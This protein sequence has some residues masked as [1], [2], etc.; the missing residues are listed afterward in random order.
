MASG[1][2]LGSYSSALVLSDVAAIQV[3]GK[4]A[5]TRNPASGSQRPMRRFCQVSS[6]TISGLAHAEGE[7]H[8]QETQHR[9][10][11]ERHG[12]AEPHLARA[13]AQVVLIG[14]HQVRGVDRAAAGLYVD[15]MDVAYRS[16]D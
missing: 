7:R 8:E 11:A 1:I 16:A 5:T 14:R 12:G 10:H 13:H 15:Q 6:P 4:S 2:A 9:H 3:N